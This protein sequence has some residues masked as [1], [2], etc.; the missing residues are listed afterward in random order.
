[1]SPEALLA[2]AAA[3][4][5]AL[6]LGA[7]QTTSQ[8]L[9]EVALERYPMLAVRRHAG[10]GEEILWGRLEVLE[11]RASPRGRRIPLDVYV[12][13]SFDPS[14]PALAFVDYNGGPAVPN[15]ANVDLFV[16]GGYSAALRDLRDILVIDQRGTGASEITC[17]A[18]A[19]VRLSALLFEPERV[20]ACLDEVRGTVDLSRYDTANSVEDL[21]EVRRWLGI[22]RLDFHGT[23]YGTR[24]GLEY[25]RRF[26]ESVHSLILTG[27][28]PP[29]FGYATFVDREVERQLQKLIERCE[30]DPHCAADFPDFRAQLYQLKERLRTRP[31]TVRFETDD[32]AAPVEV[33]VDKDV[34][35]RLVGQLF[36]SGHRIEE[37]PR[38]VDAAFAG[39]LEPLV[40]SNLRRSDR[41]MP[42]YLSQ[43]C[44]EDVDPNPVE[45]ASLAQLFTEGQMGLM[46]VGGCELWPRLS[47]PA[48]LAQPLAGD[49]PVLLL[50]GADDTQTPPRMAQWVQER[51]PHARHVI[52]PEQGHSWT[53]WSCWDSVV[54][55]FLATADL[56]A[57]DASCFLTVERPGFPR[58]EGS[59]R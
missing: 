29:V 13:P 56:D 8:S 16:R 18:F 41:V 48:W 12:I 35:V 14:P 34:F 15:A 27:C 55:E 36:L 46:E 20:R 54:Y 32:A 49:A 22:E 51:L 21:E 2:R 5:L 6:A 59:T 3:L 38:L 23:S 24:V 44:R 7:C 52:F 47:T 39:D 11:D 9:A 26:P 37:L 33:E 50:T 40:R 4:G 45:R 25:L 17:E 57:V 28:V 42:V 53:D 31:V 58:K 43:F 19:D 1:M 30:A 10:S